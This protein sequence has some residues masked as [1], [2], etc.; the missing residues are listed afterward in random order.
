MLA[1]AFLAAAVDDAR[2]TRRADPNR[3]A[4]SGDPV[5]LTVLEISAA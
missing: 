2:P 1:I 4:Q 5:D 3:P